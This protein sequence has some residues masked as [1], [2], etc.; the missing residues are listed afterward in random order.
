MELTAL[1]AHP[2]L[3]EACPSGRLDEVPDHLLAELYQHARAE[4]LSLAREVGREV[5]G[6][7][8]RLLAR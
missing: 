6:V 1:R 5:G 7:L 4:Q 2:A 8:A 3:W